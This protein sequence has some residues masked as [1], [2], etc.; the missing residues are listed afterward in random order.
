MGVLEST[1]SLRQRPVP[2]LYTTNIEKIFDTT[3]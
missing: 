1:L 2:Y 3:K